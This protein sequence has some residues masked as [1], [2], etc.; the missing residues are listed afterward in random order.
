MFWIS[1][2]F[3]YAAI[4]AARARGSVARD[5]VFSL[6]KNLR[7]YAMLRD[8]FARKNTRIHQKHCWLLPTPLNKA[9]AKQ[10]VVGKNWKQKQSW[11]KQSGPV[12]HESLFSKSNQTANHRTSKPFEIINW[13]SN[14]SATGLTLF[15]I[16]QTLIFQTLIFQMWESENK[17]THQDN[18]DCLLYVTWK[19]ENMFW[20]LAVLWKV[21]TAKAP[22]AITF[23]LL[24]TVC[25]LTAR[26][27]ATRRDSSTTSGHPQHNATSLSWVS[28][29]PFLP[30]FCFVFFFLQN[31]IPFLFCFF[32]R[33][34]SRKESKCW[35]SD[36][37]TRIRRC[38]WEYLWNT[39]TLKRGKNFCWVTERAFGKR[40][41]MLVWLFDVCLVRTKQ[42]NTTKR[43][44]NQRNKQTKE[45][46]KQKKQ[47]N[48]RN[49]QTKERN[50]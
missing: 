34:R 32:L 50:K 49:K 39:R 26:S 13:I 3:T 25:R 40:G 48:K 5:W 47:T 41:E 42:N 11:V 27:L 35:I 21:R 1:Y 14:T 15:L 2:V 30:V 28:I 37:L 9:P 4:R 22:Q 43:Q 19:K 12:S 33:K 46:N 17:V 24:L 8:W 20:T 23:C 36:I 18:L 16:F 45:T 44:A 31:T 38:G 10:I 7:V 29:F 6:L